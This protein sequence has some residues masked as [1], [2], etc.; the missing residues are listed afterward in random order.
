[1]KAV[2][3]LSAVA[4]VFYGY[5]AYQLFTIFGC[6]N[7]CQ[8]LFESPMSLVVF[9][10]IILGPVLLSFTSV[11]YYMRKGSVK[12]YLLVGTAFGGA[13]AI[14]YVGMSLAAYGSARSGVEG[15]VYPG[16]A[17]LVGVSMILP[18]VWYV[19]SFVRHG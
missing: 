17:A 9:G 18:L 15:L 11:F 13:V 2:L 1:M 7:R 19:F 5:G 4:S 8:S 6:W 14:Y 16:M 10:P 12:A 3:I